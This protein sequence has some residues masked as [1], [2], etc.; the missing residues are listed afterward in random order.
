MAK[1]EIAET[2]PQTCYYLRSITYVPHHLLKGLFVAPGSTR[3]RVR[4]YSKAELVDAG[5]V[6]VTELLWPRARS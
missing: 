5:A 2:T 6:K 1:S 4:S 3:E